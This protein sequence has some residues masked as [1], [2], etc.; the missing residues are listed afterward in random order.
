MPPA[1][2]HPCWSVSDDA[3]R[4]A[5]AYVF[6]TPVMLRRTLAQ[7]LAY[8]LHLHEPPGTEIETRVTRLADR[9]GL[10]TRWIGLRLVYREERSKSLRLAVP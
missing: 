5:Q 7:N 4:Q 3:S 8:P 6:Q 10:G 2:T 1:G 9:I